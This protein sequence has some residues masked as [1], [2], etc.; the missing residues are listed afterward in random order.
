M[1]KKKFRDIPY[2]Y[3]SADDEL[4][5]KHLFNDSTWNELETLRNKRVTGRSAKLLMRLMGDMFILRRNPFLY[6][7]L[8][9][10]P[11]RKSRFFSTAYNDLDTIETMAGNGGVIKITSQCR[12]YL[13]RL[14]KAISSHSKKRRRMKKELGDIIGEQNVFFD[15]FTLISHATD[16]TDWRLYL[17]LAVLRPTQES[18]VAP[19]LKAVEK[20]GLK[21]VP[22]G[23]G[24]G[25]TGGAVPVAPNCVM[26]N[27]EKLNRIHGINGQEFASEDGKPVT[28][29]VITVE[30]GV[31]TQNAM[32]FAEKEGLVFATDPTSSWACTIGG[33]IAENA[34]GKKAVMWGTAIDNLVSYKIAMP[35]GKLLTIRRNSHPLRKILPDDRVSFSVLDDRGTLL[36]EIHLS[37]TD[38]RKKGLGKDITNKSLNALP[39]IQKEGTDG[40]ITSAE[41]IL[42]EEY[43]CKTTFCLEFFGKD[44]EEA[45]KVIVEIS[46]EFVNEGKEAL[47]ALEH[48]DDEYM[49]AINYKVKAPRAESPKAA[50][51]IDMVGHT[52]DQI[53]SGIQRLETLLAKYENSFLFTAKND[54]EAQRFWRDRKKLG[55][56]AARTNAFKLNEDIVLPLDVIGDFTK[57]TDNYNIKEERFNQESF[58][59][60]ITTYIETAEPVEDREWLAARLPKAKELCKKNLEDL[61]NTPNSELVKKQF[62]GKL[63]AEL[64]DFFRGYN[65][66]LSEIREIYL[67]NRARRIVI[68]T[69]MHAG[70][71]NVHV[72][73]PVFSNDMEMMERASQTADAIMST[74]VK[75]NGVVSGE[76]GIGITKMKYLDKNRIDELNAYR[77]DVDPNTVMNPGQLT[78][79]EIHEKVFT[80]SFNLLEL[81]ARILQHSSLEDLATRIARCVRC[82][83]C[84]IDCC[85]FYPPK[86]MF[87]HPRNKNLAIASLIEAILY[88][89][90]R[91]HSTRFKHLKQLEEIADHCTICHKCLPPCPVNI[92]TGEVSILEREILQ[93]RK[94]KHSSIATT[95]SLKYLQSQSPLLNAVFRQSVVTWGG[96]AQRMGHKLAKPVAK[97]KYL[98]NS[99]PMQ[100]LNSPMPKAEPE[101]LRNILPACRNNQALVIKPE[102]EIKKT[103]F[104]FPGCG[105]ER[106]YS[107][108]SKASIYVLLKTGSQVVLPP[109][110]LC[111]GFPLKVNA[112]TELFNRITLRNSIMFSQISEM[113][114]YINFDACIISCGTCLDSLREIES[115]KIFNCQLSDVS[116]FALENGIKVTEP[117]KMLYHAP[118]HDSLEGGAKTL[119]NETCGYEITPVPDCCSESGTL[120]MSRPDISNSMLKR[121]R[122]SIEEAANTGNTET[123][124]ILTNCPSCIQGLGR[125]ADSGILPKHLAVELA[126]QTG[127]ELWEQDLKRLLTNSEAITF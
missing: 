86:N 9:N 120:S 76:H 80:P 122:V 126:E 7:E 18:Q 48:F 29:P 114:S 100:M 54:Q 89:V 68:A 97:I 115:D 20:L 19:L 28:R 125:N 127:G 119:L 112:K 99:Y 57:F 96:N 10:S 34:G 88:D 49:E 105:S 47:I 8:V 11:I 74:A 32:E 12:K 40:I 14:S 39:G 63:L 82:G 13:K 17:P 41:F 59:H 50:L 46:R 81:E 27:T 83:K 107:N 91:S 113:L 72:N 35:G 66:I 95:L 60:E 53:A 16:A 69:H 21:V 22:R 2:N 26:I 117:R 75:L 85:T 104:Y 106:L 44:M 30:S 15:P 124:V 79:Q 52:P 45:S 118:C 1:D 90:Q 110:F 92:D 93:A 58:I 43:E 65:R 6:Q 64:L 73:I 98:K 101:T 94:F 36:R 78:D 71:G 25:L 111:C 3:T 121:K 55:A 24:T 116:K 103:V 87:F 108:I 37:G 67:N 61:A 109:P 51:L 31:I 123:K 62:S 102:G 23:A 5:V 56:I 4:I 77:S 42:Y 38:I 70:D 84:K 33:N